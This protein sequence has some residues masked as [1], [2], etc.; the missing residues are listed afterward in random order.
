LKRGPA[1]WADVVAGNRLRGDL[2]VAWITERLLR[3]GASLRRW[4]ARQC[5]IGSRR[6]HTEDRRS[7]WSAP[8]WRAAARQLR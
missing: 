1:L 8:T 6:P 7:R 5:G 2:I 4:H 3:S